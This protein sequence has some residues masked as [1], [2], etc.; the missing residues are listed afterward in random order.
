MTLASITHQEKKDIMSEKKASGRRA[1]RVDGKGKVTF[2]GHTGQVLNIS[3]TGI[4]IQTQEDVEDLAQTNCLF[5]I[6]FQKSDIF[7]PNSHFELSGTICFC[8]FN[9]EDKVYIVG[10]NLD[11]LTDEQQTLLDNFLAFQWDAQLFWEF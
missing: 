10:V 1:H 7:Q 6:D 2:N 8:S 3:R 11:T 4:G 5:T 9:E